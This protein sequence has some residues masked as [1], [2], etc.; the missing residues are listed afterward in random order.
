MQRFLSTSGGQ[1]LLSECEW[2]RWE[3]MVE[4][5]GHISIDLDATSGD[6]S[7]KS[8]KQRFRFANLFTSKWVIRSDPRYLEKDSIVSD[9]S[10]R[11]HPMT[12]R[13]TH[14][15]RGGLIIIKFFFSLIWL[16]RPNPSVICIHHQLKRSVQCYILHLHRSIPVKILL[17]LHLRQWP[18]PF[19]LTTWT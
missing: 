5:L 7:S 19:H 6:K 3:R 12:S 4:F 17:L 11:T 18:N 14:R 9:P 15:T 1:I 8:D 16:D 10:A 2:R 13:I